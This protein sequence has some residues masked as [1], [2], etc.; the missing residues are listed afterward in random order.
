MIDLQTSMTA[1][2]AR[3]LVERL[4]LGT[5]PSGHLRNFTVGRASQLKQLVS[6]LD[7]TATTPEA[8]LVQANYGA[9][10]THLLRLLHETAL[11]NGFAVSYI[12][13]INA[14]LTKLT[15]LYI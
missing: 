6:S 14:W 2:E 10:K 8:L 12:S 15:F 9:G 4:T 5:P 7:S 11:E 1:K 3:D 13:R